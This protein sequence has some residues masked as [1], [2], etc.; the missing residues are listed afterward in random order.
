MLKLIVI[1]LNHL[2]IQMSN[3]NLILNASSLKLLKIDSIE[4]VD[5]TSMKLM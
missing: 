2:R 1:N 5:S 4:N 3:N